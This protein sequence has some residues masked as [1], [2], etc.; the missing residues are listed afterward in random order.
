MPKFLNHAEVSALSVWAKGGT[1]LIIIPTALFVGS[2]G[3]AIFAAVIL[4]FQIYRCPEVARR[5]MQQGVRR[6]ILPIAVGLFVLHLAFGS[7][8]GI[9]FFLS[10]LLNSARFIFLLSFGLLFVESTKPIEIPQ[11]L[12]RSRVPHKYGMALMIGYRT[13]PLIASRM[14]AIIMT[15]RGRGAQWSWHLRS[16]HRM[17]RMLLALMVPAVYSSLEISMALSDTLYVRGYRP[18]RPISLP[19]RGGSRTRSFC[20]TVAGLGTL[21]VGLWEAAGR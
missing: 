8:D 1:Y 10:W 21:F 4:S 20:L 9:E 18:D 13:V 2:F 16:L 15:Q 7:Y 14:Q 12:V 17:P 3:S 11:A 5:R 6:S 19:P